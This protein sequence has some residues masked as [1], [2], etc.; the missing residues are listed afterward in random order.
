MEY[1]LGSR[2]TATTG[3]L[4]TT[5]SRRNDSGVSI[6]VSITLEKLVQ[7]ARPH[8]ADAHGHLQFGAGQA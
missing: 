6:A 4:R 2:L 3:M 1:V 7:E 8:F 5:R